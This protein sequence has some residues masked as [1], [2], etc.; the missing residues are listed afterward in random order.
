MLEKDEN[1]RL[2]R[3][4]YRGKYL[5]ASRTGGLALR[6]QTK[7]SG[8]HLTANSKHGLR[9]S[10]RVAKG[11]QVAFQNGRFILRG[12]YGRGP[13]KLNL[14]KSGVSVSSKTEIGTINWFKPRYSSA[15][16]AGIQ[17]R[18]KNA[19]YLHALLLLIQILIALTLFLVQ[20]VIR[21]VQV[22]FWLAITLTEQAQRRWAMRHAKALQAAE[23]KWL[24][25]FS[26]KEDTW[27]YESLKWCFLHLGQGQAWEPQPN[28]NNSIADDLTTYLAASPLPQPLNLETLFGCLAETYEQ[29]AGEEACLELFF[30]LDNAAVAT[31]GRNQL[32]E[33]LLAA[34]AAC[35]GIDLAEEGSFSGAKAHI[36]LDALDQS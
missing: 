4:E 29:T 1:G 8:V 36:A 18:G 35:C 6:A 13:T 26:A 30:D 14:S 10:T 33:R 11:T 27:L 20:I 21:S 3:I 34:Y 17:V 22:V 7:L 2:K 32:Q 12:R 9:A 23:T 15:K 5:R 28:A 16:I 19:L 25:A 31:G 24:D